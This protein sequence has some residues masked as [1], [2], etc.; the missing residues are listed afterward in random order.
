[1]KYTQLFL[2]WKKAAAC[3]IAIVSCDEILSFSVDH[4]L[5]I[6]S[7]LTV[8][9]LLWCRLLSDAPYQNSWLTLQLIT[10]SRNPI[11]IG[12]GDCYG[13]V[14]GTGTIHHYVVDIMFNFKINNL[15]FFVH[16]SQEFRHVFFH[17]S[18]RNN[19]NS[20][21]A[22][23]TIRN[24]GWKRGRVSFFVFHEIT[25]IFSP[26][27]SGLLMSGTRYNSLFPIR[28]SCINYRTPNY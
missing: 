12:Y 2:F 4:L 21:C 28:F 16:Y 10:S 24:M 23:A 11:W 27:I 6:P 14:T 22:S 8:R 7:L 13:M 5:N 15:A 17:L 9:V 3:K 26:I 25:F 19:N 1:M 20:Y 18:D